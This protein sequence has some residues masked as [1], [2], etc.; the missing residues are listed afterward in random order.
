MGEFEH[1]PPGGIDREA[2]EG[3]G[4]ASDVT[5]EAFELVALNGGARD[6]CVEREALQVRGQQLGRGRPR[7]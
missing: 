2:L 6:C 7:Q 5:G 4:R 3:D 1:D